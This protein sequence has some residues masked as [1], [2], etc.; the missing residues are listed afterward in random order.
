MKTMS[1]GKRYLF[2]KTGIRLDVASLCLSA[3]VGSFCYL[4]FHYEIDSLYFIFF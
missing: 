4:V 3:R 1:E 2:A